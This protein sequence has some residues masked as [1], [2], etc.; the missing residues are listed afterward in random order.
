M[1]VA[2]DHAFALSASHCEA[3]V[4]LPQGSQTSQN[5][6]S[7][8]WYLNPGTKKR[9]IGTAKKLAQPELPEESKV[10]VVEVRKE[11][12]S[13]LGFKLWE[14][15]STSLPKDGACKGKYWYSNLVRK[16]TCSQSV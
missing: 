14:L 9:K 4:S 6:G 16:A 12:L 15:Q 13:S 2:S 10:W 8:S 1:E 7:V 3:H 5:Q 11:W